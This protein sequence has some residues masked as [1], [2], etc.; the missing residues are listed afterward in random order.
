MTCIE[1]N[2]RCVLYE[3]LIFLV[4]FAFE[5]KKSFFPVYNLER[6]LLIDMKDYFSLINMHSL[7]KVGKRVSF[8]T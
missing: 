1:K 2:F 7:W 8:I 4:F 3:K 5:R 6:L